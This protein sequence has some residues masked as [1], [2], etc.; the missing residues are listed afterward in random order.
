MCRESDW[1]LSG[2]G[3]KEERE[4]GRRERGDF[5]LSWER[6]VKGTFNVDASTTAK[7]CERLSMIAA[8]FRSRVILNCQ[9]RSGNIG[10][11]KE[12]MTIMLVGQYG[13]GCNMHVEFYSVVEIP[14]R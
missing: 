8:L 1:G 9:K 4:N 2:K 3:W 12:H 14:A 7:S 6:S 11:S 10:A 5:D 13:R